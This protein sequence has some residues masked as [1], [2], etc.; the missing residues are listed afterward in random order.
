MKERLLR[1]QGL[2]SKMSFAVVEAIREE[3]LEVLL[4]EWE[5]EE[6]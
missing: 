2:R 4:Y 3:L 5:Q 1:D 6:K